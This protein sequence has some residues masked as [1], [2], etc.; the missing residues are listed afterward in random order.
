MPPSIRP[1]TKSSTKITRCPRR[2][3]AALAPRARRGCINV[4][5][6]RAPHPLLALAPFWQRDQNRPVR[7]QV[8]RPDHAHHPVLP[9]ADDGEGALVLPAVEL[10]VRDEL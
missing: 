8:L 1:E 5:V 6:L 9:L 2:P 4:R 10:I 3:Y 7:G